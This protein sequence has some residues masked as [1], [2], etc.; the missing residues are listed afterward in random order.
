[1][2]IVSTDIDCTEQNMVRCTDYLSLYRRFI[3]VRLLGYYANTK[4]LTFDYGYSKREFHN[5]DTFP[6]VLPHSIK[7]F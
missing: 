1:M 4:S 3:D 5:L 7:Y 2:G 6:Y